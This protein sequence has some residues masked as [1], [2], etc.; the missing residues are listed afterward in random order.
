[1]IHQLIGTEDDS[2]FE[3][4][5]DENKKKKVN[6]HVAKKVDSYSIFHHT[7]L[8][9]IFICDSHGVDNVVFYILLTDIPKQLK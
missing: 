1:M 7:E 6:Q 5:F 8:K 3:N 9:N 4:K 2:F